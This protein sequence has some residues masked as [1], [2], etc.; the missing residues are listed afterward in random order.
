MAAGRSISVS[1]S[2]AALG[3]GASK[4]EEDAPA[5]RAADPTRGTGGRPLLRQLVLSAAVFIALGLVSLWV[6]EA[7]LAEAVDPEQLPHGRLWLLCAVLALS[8]VVAGGV[9]QALRHRW[10]QAEQDRRHVDALASLN[11]ITAAITARLGSSQELLD[12]LAGSAAALAGMKMAAV[13][14]LDE[15]SQTLRIVSS[16]GFPPGHALASFQS[17]EA[18]LTWECIREDRIV[19]LEDAEHSDRPDLNR[20]LMARMEMRSCMTIPLRIGRRRIGA[21]TLSDPRPSRFNDRELRLAELLGSQVAVT[22]ANNELYEQITESLRAQH[23]LLDQ[24][25]KLAAVT[26]AVY[27]ASTLEESLKRV[28]GLAPS[29]LGGDVC[30]VDMVQGDGSGGRMVIAAATPPFHRFIGHRY[31]GRGR[32]VHNVIIRRQMMVIEEAARD[33]V[34]DPWVVQTFNAG[35][36][37]FLPLFQADGAPLGTLRLIRHAPG[38]FSDEQLRLAQV[39]ASRAAAA[40]ESARLHQRLKRDAETRAML[41]RE[42]NHRVKN[43]LAGIVGLLSTQPHELSPE[44]Q[45]W[46]GRVIERI[47]VMGRAHELFVGGPQRVSLAGLVDQLLPTLAVVKPVGVRFAKELDGVPVLLAT[48]RAVALAMVLHELCYNAMVHG[49]GEEGNITIRAGSDHARVT[50]EVID[51]GKGYAATPVAVAAGGSERAIGGDDAASAAV[52]TF[53]AS[54][55]QEGWGLRLVQGLVMRE[56]RGRF[57]IR[58]GPQGGTIASIEFPIAADE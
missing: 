49:T 3:R 5:A 26:V 15:A 48:E 51:D 35:G 9:L 43:N 19:T 2:A 54:P 55:H 18:P 31:D 21:L 13:M 45:R 44:A 24:R 4:V 42:L 11:E 12:Q 17:H 32:H 39:F 7:A 37:I 47:T 20:E 23:R 1:D 57:T 16:S 34:I 58:H 56:L 53:A 36:M 41:L 22:L 14:L 10:M 30:L 27:Q 25:E 40:I 50:V 52:P 38:P 6:V 33:P 28:V 46:I 8:A 29:A